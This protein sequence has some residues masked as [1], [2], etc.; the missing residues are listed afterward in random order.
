MLGRVGRNIITS[1]RNL[2]CFADRWAVAR[3]CTLA[4]KPSDT[5]DLNLRAAQQCKIIEDGSLRALFQQQT[6]LIPPSPPQHL[7][8]T[9]RTE[10]THSLLLFALRTSQETYA[11]SI[12]REVLW[13]QMECQIDTVIGTRSGYFQSF[14]CLI[15]TVVLCGSCRLLY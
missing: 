8:P 5:N 9:F 4:K 1:W 10:H 14:L 3:G 13:C 11:S 2:I 7:I 15:K 6:L 12:R